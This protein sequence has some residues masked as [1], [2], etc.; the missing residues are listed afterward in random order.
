MISDEIKRSVT[1]FDVAERYGK[2]ERGGFILCPLHNEKTASLKLYDNDRGYYCFGCHKGGDV[3]SFVMDVRGLNFMQAVRRINRDFN[4]GLLGSG[5]SINAEPVKK[6]IREDEF[7]K[8][9]LDSQE[10]F[11]LGEMIKHGD[12]GRV[13]E[14]LDR[15]AERRIDLLWDEERRTWKK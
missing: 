7:N 5:K 15:I 6:H 4:L 8:L 2:I 14:E 11:W 10:H 13:K 1:M 9:L 12:T 3:I